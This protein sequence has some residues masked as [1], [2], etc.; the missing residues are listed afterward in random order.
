ML[1]HQI[2]FYL[3]TITLGV[4]LTQYNN[5]APTVGSSF[6]NSSF[7]DDEENSKMSACEVNFDGESVCGADDEA[8]FESMS[9][10][11]GNSEIQVYFQDSMI[12]VSGT[13]RAVDASGTMIDWRIVH[14]NNPNQVI[15]AL[16]PRDR[17][18]SC[19]RGRFNLK[20]PICHDPSIVNCSQFDDQVNDFGKAQAP[21]DYLLQLDLVAYNQNGEEIRNPF[22]AQANVTLK[23]LAAPII[24]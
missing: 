10:A 6:G 12:T 4:L 20:I 1:N 15:L 17:P 9:L 5:C 19:V 8:I 3:I 24:E 21:G 13:C 18:V 11:P 14:P 23:K 7:L 2:R 16:S 22:L